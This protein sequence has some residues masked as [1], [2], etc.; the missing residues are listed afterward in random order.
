MADQQHLDRLR[1]G[2]ST[3]KAWMAEQRPVFH[4]DL[5]GANLGYADL[6]GADLGRANLSCA[7]LSEA[8]LIRVLQPHFSSS[9]FKG[10]RQGHS[11]ER[12]QNLR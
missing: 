3:W 8:N 2:V 5:S 1:Q 6:S 7:D 12:G 10:S 11:I 4:P 9:A